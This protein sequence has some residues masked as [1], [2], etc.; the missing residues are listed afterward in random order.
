MRV[1]RSKYS[2]EYAPGFGPALQVSDCSGQTSQVCRL[3]GRTSARVAT[4]LRA[5]L[6]EVG[7]Q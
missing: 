6:R 1:E 5:G 3:V 7:V 4:G 2:S